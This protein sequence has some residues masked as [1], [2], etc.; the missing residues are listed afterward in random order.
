MNGKMIE[1][2]N[3]GFLTVPVSAKRHGLESCGVPT[4]GP[5]DPFRCILANRLAGNED[6]AA[7]L[8][9]A[10]TMPGVRFSDERVIAA[11]GGIGEIAIRRGGEELA[12]PANASV[13]V[14]P[15]DELISRPLEGG[16]RAY[17]A[18]SGG[19]TEAGIALRTQSAEAG[20]RLGLNENV[21]AVRRAITKM[22][23][24]LPG[25]NAEL[26][27]IEGVQW[28]RFSR[29]GRESFLSG[30]YSYTPESSRMG[31][32]LEGPQIG[33]KE[34]ADGNIIS[35][36]MLPGDIQITSAGQPILMLADCPA[37]G[38]YAKIAHVIFAD[39]PTAAQLQ[40]GAKL[41]FRL[42]DLPAAHTA[43]RRL[44]LAL[45]GSIRD[46]AEPD[47]NAL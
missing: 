8:E 45:D 37:S 22:P 43:L 24:D 16:M 18:V 11:V 5:A 39:L 30:E 47:G 4:G 36:G 12:F 10:F 35:E 34:G 40:P 38:G 32:R 14:F 31:I 27:V 1:I 21:P 2:T 25:E 20:Q 42:V 44:M 23:F 17:I 9:A 28:E 33:F 15:E 46:L 13:R 3:K 26:R 41:R 6:D 7:A 29:E 19:L